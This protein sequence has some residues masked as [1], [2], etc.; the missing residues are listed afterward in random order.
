MSGGISNDK[1][2]KIS[3]SSAVFGRKT[4]FCEKQQD[5][6]EIFWPNLKAYIFWKFEL[7]FF[8]GEIIFFISVRL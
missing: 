4:L 3:S 2:S 5:I 8:P 1:T 7:T 6:F